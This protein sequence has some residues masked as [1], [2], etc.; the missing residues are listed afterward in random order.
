MGYLTSARL[1]NFVTSHEFVQQIEAMMETYQEMTA[2]I[3]KERTYYEKFWKARESQAQRLLLGMA[4]IVG[5]MQGHNW[6]SVDAKD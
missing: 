1:Y 6:T 4:S 2:Q 3:T 5:S